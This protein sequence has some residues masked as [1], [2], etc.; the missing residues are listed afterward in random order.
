M[1]ALFGLVLAGGRSR[2]FGSEKAVATLG[3]RSLLDLAVAR[4]ARDCAEVAVNAPAGSAA[5]AQARA[6][7]RRLISDAAGDPDGPLSGIKAGLGWAAGQG[8]G[9]LAVIPCDAPL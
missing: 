4:L 7:G 1:T 5:A 2:R 6:L 8:V 9:H 3:G